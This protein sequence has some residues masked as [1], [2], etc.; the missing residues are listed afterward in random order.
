M[1]HYHVRVQLGEE[2]NINGSMS[3]DMYRSHKDKAVR[4]LLQDAFK[5]P[6][7]NPDMIKGI[8]VLDIML[9]TEQYL[10]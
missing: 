7:L 10:M 9:A 3:L 6:Q 1:L 2:H 8:T 5:V 4:K